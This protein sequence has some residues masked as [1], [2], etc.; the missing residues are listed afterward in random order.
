[1]DMKTKE[2]KF[3]KGLELFLIFFMLISMLVGCRS[4]RETIKTG[5]DTKEQIKEQ[6]DATIITKTQEQVKSQSAAT[7]VD[8][9]SDSTSLAAESHTVT[10]DSTSSQVLDFSFS[11]PDS[12]GRQHVTHLVLTTTTSHHGAVTDYIGLM[13]RLVNQGT[14]L[15]TTTSQER[16]TKSATEATT[17]KNTDRK[18][19]TDQAIDSVTKSDPVLKTPLTIVAIIVSL[20]VLIL[21]Y[22]GLKKYKLL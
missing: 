11:P 4:V 7:T 2:V 19:K 22:L 8:S 5:L 21:A 6:E 12:T 20:G 14:S 9:R 3:G 16:N 18:T 10:T 13:G 17:K 15:A 1:M